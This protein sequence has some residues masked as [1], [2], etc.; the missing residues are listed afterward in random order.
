MSKKNILHIVYQTKVIGWVERFIESL[1][2][3][4]IKGERVL[5][6]HNSKDVINI[7]NSIDSLNETNKSYNPLLLIYF[8]IKRWYL[9][10]KYCK[11]NNIHICF[12]HWDSLNLSA[13][14]SKLLFRNKSKIII[15]LHNSLSFYDNFG[16]SFYKHLFTYFYPKADKIITISAEMQEELKKSWYTNTHLL[17]NP[18]DLKY[19]KKAQKEEIS[20]YKNLF[21]NGKYTFITIWR[22]EKVKNIPFLINCFK[23]HNSIERKS[24]FVVIWDGDLSSTLKQEAWEGN[25]IHFIPFQKNIYKYLNAADSFIFS[26]FNEWFGRVLIESLACSTPILSHDFKYGGREILRESNNWEA[27]KK[28]EIH[29]NGILTPYLDEMTFVKAMWVIQKTRFDKKQIQNNIKKYSIDNS[30][31]S[32]NK[33]IHEVSP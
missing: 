19:I 6:L 3:N 29:Q 17:Y 13:I 7:S 12:S 27:C 21:S 1:L 8:T 33:I 14:I 10:K 23:K 2:W 5:K 25:N 26:S 31:L 16:S 11:K 18:I 32:Y 28:I 30:L 4:S 22:L 20:E 9:Y 15:F 24:Q